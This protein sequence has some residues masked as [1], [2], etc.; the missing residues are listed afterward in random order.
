[1]VKKLALHAL[2]ITLV[3]TIG[4][5]AAFAQSSAELTSTVKT[6]ETPAA[7]L[8]TNKATTRNEKL[9][10]GMEKLVADS[11]AGKV[12]P[13]MRSQL[14]PKQSNGLSTTAKV[15]IGVGIAV[16][17]LAILVIHAKNHMFDDFTLGHVLH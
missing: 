1:M 8:A 13:A 16:V 4:G 14:Q 2:A 15:A 7:G 9:K 11:K 5:T 17:V 6:V 12:A 3:F 10:A